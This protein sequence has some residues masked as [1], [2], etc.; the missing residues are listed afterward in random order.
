MMQR[1][2][3]KKKK[4]LIRSTRLADRCGETQDGKLKKKDRE[5][6]RVIRDCEKA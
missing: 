3:M 2:L 5:R 6:M 4:D 1:T